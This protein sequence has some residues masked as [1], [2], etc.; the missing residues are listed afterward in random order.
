MASEGER[1]VGPPLGEMD[2]D[3]FRRAGHRIVD[4]IADYRA[5]PECYPVLS[6]CRPG[7]V[8]AQLPRAAPSEAESIECILNDF[9]RLILPGITHWNHPAFFAYFAITGS[10]PGILGELLASALNVN[11]MLSRTS[12]AATELEFVRTGEVGGEKRHALET[13]RSGVFAIGDVCSGSVKRVAAAVGEGAQVVL[14]LH[15]YLARSG[16]AATRSAR[17]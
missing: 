6:R 5:H 16:S 8:R 12:P 9:E 3:E 2:L 7:E 17:A 4:W 15:A 14:A 10:G 1:A 11:A 13:N